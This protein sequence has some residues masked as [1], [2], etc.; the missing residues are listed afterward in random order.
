MSR[1][2]VRRV[3]VIASRE[4]AISELGMWKEYFQTL[5]ISY[6]L[7][8]AQGRIIR[9]Y[10]RMPQHAVAE[11]IVENVSQVTIKGLAYEFA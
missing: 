1:V 10:H 11:E 8:L 7:T 3:W 6:E 5:G 4:K 9:R 2:T